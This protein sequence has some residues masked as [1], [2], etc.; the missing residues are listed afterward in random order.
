MNRMR[1]WK[2]SIY[3][4][5]LFLAG[6]VTGA[7]LTVKVG[8]HF[9]SPARMTER[10]RGDLQLKLKLSPEQM[11]Q[12]APL[13]DEFRVVM[14]AHMLESMSNCNARIAAVLT[15]EQ[16]VKFAEIEREQQEFARRISKN[17][18]HPPPQ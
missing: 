10:W 5:A 2:I 11:Q 16:K 12:I 18:K 9:M 3:L 1:K 15:P 6:T 14:G 17:E 8:R 13:L 7:F 4:S